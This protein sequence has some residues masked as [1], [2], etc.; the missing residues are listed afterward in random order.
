MKTTRF[1]MMFVAA[2]AMMLAS[3][4]KDDNTPAENENEK[5]TV[6]LN[7]TEKMIVGTWNETESLYITSRGEVRDTAS[8]YEEGEYSEITFKADR[9]YSSIYY[10]N[11]GDSEDGGTWSANEST[12][13][14]ADEMGPND[15]QI[16]QLDAMTFIISYSEDGEDEEGPYTVYIVVK[17]TKE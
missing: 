6:T 9:T 12:I 7:D 8:M 5:P 14:M 16:D 1:I 11:Y 17:M 15:F 4:G 10:S 3:C 2:A 13:T